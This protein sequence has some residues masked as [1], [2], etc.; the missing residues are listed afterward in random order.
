MTNKEIIE[1]KAREIYGDFL[2][3]DFLKRSG[4]IP[5]YTKTQWD[6][7]GLHVKEGEQGYLVKL[8]NCVGKKWYM[9][10]VYVYTIYQV[11]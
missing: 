2:V 7:R 5:L 3:N 8:N 1:R 4:E 10:E 6:K 11:E 9:Y